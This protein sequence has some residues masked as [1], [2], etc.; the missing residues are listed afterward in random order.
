[1]YNNYFSFF[2]DAI[3]SETQN[4]IASNSWIYQDN[5]LEKW[6]NL[7][8]VK[9]GYTNLTSAE[10]KRLTNA[11]KRWDGLDINQ[12]LFEVSHI[13]D[14]TQPG[15]YLFGNRS[16]Y[17]LNCKLFSYNHEVINQ[18]A[19]A[20]IPAAIQALDALIEASE[21]TDKISVET[22]EQTNM[23]MYYQKQEYLL[24]SNY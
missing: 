22:K 14:E 4:L 13:E 5:P 1:L 18:S 11:R 19:S 20:G 7:Q 17:R 21:S 8:N 12:K 9:E 6:A 15:F 10:N 3:D 23:N 16:G 2:T 24:N